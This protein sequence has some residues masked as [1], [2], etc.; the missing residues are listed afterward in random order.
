MN[1]NIDW[2]DFIH[3]CVEFVFMSLVVAELTDRRKPKA[4]QVILLI[5]LTSSIITTINS[6]DLPYHAFITIFGLAG[7]SALCLKKT[8]IE[9]LTDSI[10]A[11]VCT[12]L[13]EILCELLSMGVAKVIRFNIDIVKFI[14]LVLMVIFAWLVFAND[15]VQ[16][17]LSKYYY[18]N[19][20]YLL[21]FWITIMII[22]AIAVNMWATEDTIYSNKK[23]EISILI[24][25]YILFNFTFLFNLNR[26]REAER[27]LFEAHEYEDYL[28]DVMEEMNSREHEHNNQ[29]QHILSIAKAEHID[30]KVKRITDYTEMLVSEF[31]GQY[32]Q[33]AITD[34][35]TISIF[36]HQVR[37][38]AV[39]EN[40][41]LD[42]LIDKPFPEYRVPEKDLMEL[43]Q[44]AVNNAFEAV[45]MLEP[46][47]RSIFMTFQHSYIEIANTLLYL[48]EVQYGVS[49]K[50]EGHGY[51][52]KNMKKIADKYELDLSEWVEGNQYIVNI[53]F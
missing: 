21:W 28:H 40:V 43:L 45:A 19:R 23:I 18:P 15:K 20:R 24:V 46:E 7:F 27:K 31:K 50:A 12:L 48:K 13:Y 41:K 8:F 10:T 53:K 49:T 22:S 39:N 26:K 29:I 1:I 5:I 4:W 35:I 52:M 30:D 14:F 34:N 42:Y 32:S 44:N 25:I 11:F 9:A 38:R 16:E 3:G 2:I 36:L 51:G 33:S 47:K 37:E 6:F 17:F